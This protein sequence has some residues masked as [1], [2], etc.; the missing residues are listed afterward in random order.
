MAAALFR[1]TGLRA[2]IC[3]F[4]FFQFNLPRTTTA[5]G[6]ALLAGSAVIRLF[7]LSG[8]FL[9]SDPPTYVLVYLALIVAGDLVAAAVMIVPSIPIALLGWVFGAFVST[10]TVGMYI[11]SRTAGLP[12]VPELVG[13][14]H[15]ALGT[16]SLLLPAAFLGLWFTVI[17]QRNIVYPQRRGWHD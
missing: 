14:W 6:I 8:H 9:A 15:Y 11:A 12:G 10:A 13:R 17:T 7:W 5:A 3:F 4:R 1:W 2:L 16:V